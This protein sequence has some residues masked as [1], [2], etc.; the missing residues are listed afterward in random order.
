[1]SKSND[2]GVQQVSQP[3]PTNCNDGSSR[4]TRDAREPQGVGV[5]RQRQVTG[6]G[7]KSREAR[8]SRKQIVRDETIAARETRAFGLTH[9]GCRGTGFQ[10]DDRSPVAQRSRGGRNREAR[11]ERQES[12]GVMRSRKQIVRDETIAAREARAFRPT[13]GLPVQSFKHGGGSKP[14]KVSK[15]AG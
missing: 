4:G 11:I 13:L 3:T 2:E 8:G 7:S 5:V 14:P 10:D 6:G 15:G 1:M 9:W 12:R